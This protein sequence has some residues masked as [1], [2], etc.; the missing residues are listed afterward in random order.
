MEA[1]VES[2]P[3]APAPGAEL[4]KDEEPSEEF[5]VLSKKEKERLKKEKEKV[6]MQLLGGI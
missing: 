4:Q 6:R 2:T 3:P 5:T 1:H